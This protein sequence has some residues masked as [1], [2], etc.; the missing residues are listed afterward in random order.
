MILGETLRVQIVLH[1]LL[2]AIAGVVKS[3]TLKGFVIA[4]KSSK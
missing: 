3:T 4:S 2:A 1:F